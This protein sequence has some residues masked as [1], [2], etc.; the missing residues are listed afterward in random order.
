MARRLVK[1]EYEDLPAL[2]SCAD[3]IEAHS[4]FEAPPAPPLRRSSPPL[5]SQSC[6]AGH[7]AGRHACQLD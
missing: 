2:L 7:T 4:F 3:A 1:V 5:I 6:R